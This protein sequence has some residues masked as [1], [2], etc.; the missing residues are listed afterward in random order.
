MFTKNRMKRSLETHFFIKR[1]TMFINAIIGLI[2]VGFTFFCIYYVIINGP[3]QCIINCCKSVKY[4]I[5]EVSD[6]NPKNTKEINI[7]N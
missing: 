4:I 6:Y 7:V 3:E 1:I 5:S 2:A